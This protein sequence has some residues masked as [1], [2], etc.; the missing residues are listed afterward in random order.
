[1]GRIH[2]PIGLVERVMEDQKLWKASHTRV[3]TEHNQ[4][5]Q[6]LSPYTFFVSNS[7]DK[8]EASY[9]RIHALENTKSVNVTETTLEKERELVLNEL[10]P[11]IPLGLAFNQLTDYIE[12]VHAMVYHSGY[13]TDSVDEVK[14]AELIREIATTIHQKALSWELLPEEQRCLPW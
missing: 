8:V 10:Q 1:M 13:T 6:V 3:L 9:R 12:A 7:P 2:I 11:Y 4:K 14:G 5:V